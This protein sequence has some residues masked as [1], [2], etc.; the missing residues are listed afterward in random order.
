[1]T[2]SIS[3]PICQ[4][5]CST[6][7]VSCPKCGHPFSKDNILNTNVND[8]TKSLPSGSQKENLM[9]KPT[10]NHIIVGV[11]AI[12]LVSILGFFLYNRT[13]SETDERIRA[14][15]NQMRAIVLNTECKKN[16]FSEKECKELGDSVKKNS[17]SDD[18]IKS[19]N[20]NCKERMYSDKECE[21]YKQF[22]IVN[23]RRQI[24]G[25][26]VIFD[27]KYRPLK[28]KN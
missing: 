24:N 1:M 26:E 16:N 25:E 3:C 4:N 8:N 11:I 2:N 9:Y 27:E 14:L 28:P 19:I 22:V 12:M 20:N 18:F 23:L 17:S 21:E 7:A 15:R 6:Q 5:L 10:K 13:G